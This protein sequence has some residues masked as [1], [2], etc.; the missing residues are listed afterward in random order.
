MVS[1]DEHPR[2]SSIRKVIL[3]RQWPLKKKIELKTYYLKRWFLTHHRSLF[4][5]RGK[6]NK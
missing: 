2:K 3:G 4:E 6:K 1:L 5:K